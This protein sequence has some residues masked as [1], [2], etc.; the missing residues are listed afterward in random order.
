MEGSL[1]EDQDPKAITISQYLGRGAV[2]RGRMTIT[3]GLTT[4]VST[5]PYLRNE[6]DEEAVI[7]GIETLKRSL[8]NVP[9]LEWLHPAPN[10][11][12]RDYVKG[13]LVSWATR[14]ANHW[15][16]TAKLGNND[17]RINNGDSVVDTNTKVY[18][19]DNVFVVD[20]S[21]F[22]GHVTTNPSSYIVVAAEHAASRILALAP[23]RAAA[24]WE[25]C[26]G[27]EWRGAFQC[28]AGLTCKPLNPYYSQVSSFYFSD[29][30][31]KLTDSSASSKG[32]EGLRREV[33]EVVG[34]NTLNSRFDFLPVH[35]FRFAWEV[36]PATNVHIDLDLRGVTS[37]EA[38]CRV[39]RVR[40]N[41]VRVVAP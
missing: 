16:G 3:P 15:I 9:N 13:Y 10:I 27:R 5:H 24:V 36:S 11:T 18:G 30:K 25:Q 41:G 31:N 40:E 35:R 28:A 8:A 6:Y 37:S 19:T 29:N 12:P 14:R 23:A 33:M 2:S 1:G 22:P 38:P 7:R 26:G 39:S 4:E 20:A 17:G 21:I 34:A 32:Y